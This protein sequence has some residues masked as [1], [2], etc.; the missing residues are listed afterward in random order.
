MAA[1]SSESDSTTLTGFAETLRLERA[2]AADAFVVREFLRG[3]L[4][5]SSTSDS[6]FFTGAF[7]V[8]ALR[9]REGLGSSSSSGAKSSSSPI[10]GRDFFGGGVSSSASSTS[11]SGTSSREGLARVLDLVLEEAAR[12]GG[13]LLRE[14]GFVLTVSA[15]TSSEGCPRFLLVATGFSAAAGGGWTDAERVD[16]LGGMLCYY[17]GSLWSL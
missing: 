12:D 3:G 13:F 1:S 15:S 17:R 14:G 16:L 6:S 11:D 5:S 2:G 8:S 10:E 7:R 4:T 9:D